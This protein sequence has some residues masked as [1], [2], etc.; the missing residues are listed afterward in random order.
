MTATELEFTAT[1]LEFTATELEFTATEPEFTATEPEFTNTEF[2]FTPIETPTSTEPPA[3]G[4]C[5]NSP[6]EPEDI[7][8]QQVITQDPFCCANFWDSL[9]ETQYRE[10]VCASQVTRVQPTVIAEAFSY[11]GGEGAILDVELNQKLDNNG[12]EVWEVISVVIIE[13]GQNYSTTGFSSDFVQFSAP[14]GVVQNSASAII[15]LDREIP[16]LDIE[17]PFSAGNGAIFSIT[18]SETNDFNNN[19]VWQISSVDVID[20]GTGYSNFG[21]FVQVSLVDGVEQS[22]A[23][24]Q[25]FNKRIEPTLTASIPF[26]SNGSGASLSV[27]LSPTLDFSERPAWEIVSVSVIDGGNGYQSSDF[28]EFTLIN[29]TFMSSAFASLVVND[30]IIESVVVNA[31]GLYYLETDEIDEVII[32]SGGEYY[33]T[34]GSIESIIVT[35]SGE[36]YEETPCDQ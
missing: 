6:Y 27:V 5:V 9:C 3:P 18:L 17:L 20:G 12:K 29:G 28:V 1:E 32:F 13:S 30:G 36:Y 11:N 4:G 33:K 26:S 35:N 34:N 21:E 2:E 19:T 10:C 14:E 23:S 25:T 15:I 7:C 24:F 22:A 16:T 8:Y 31:G